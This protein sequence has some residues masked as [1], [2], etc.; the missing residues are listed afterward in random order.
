M[1]FTSPNLVGDI[2]AKALPPVS[3][4]AAAHVTSAPVWR[5]DYRTRSSGALA[6]DLYQ[7]KTNQNRPRHRSERAAVAA[8]KR[9]SSQAGGTG[10][11]SS[12]GAAGTGQDGTGEFA[13]A[14]ITVP[15]A[16]TQGPEAPEGAVGTAGILEPTEVPVTGPSRQDLTSTLSGPCEPVPAP[17][18]AEPP[19]GAD[20]TLH[21]IVL[22]PL[23]V[24]EWG[25]V[26][27]S[28]RSEARPQ[29]VPS[30]V[31]TTPVRLRPDP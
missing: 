27:F 16:A 25:G 5:G 29:S 15:G 4:S 8:L 17:I 11:A 12:S 1:L 13:S 9:N 26:V 6:G 21:P 10:G 18:A 28:A 3:A 20:L 2:A 19:A 24:T 7:R 14:S 23:V 22:P 31:L 30:L